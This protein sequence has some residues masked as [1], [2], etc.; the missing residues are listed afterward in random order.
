MGAIVI[1]V[2]ASMVVRYFRNIDTG[3]L[4]QKDAATTQVEERVSENSYTVTSGDTLWK[5]AEVRYQSGYNWVDIAQANDL[6]DPGQ[7][8]TGQV[9][10]LPNVEAKTVTTTQTPTSE[11][12]SITGATYSIQKG[13]SLWEIAVRA[14]G[15]GYRWTQIAQENQLTNPNLIHSGNQ[16]VLSR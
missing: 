6:A 8:E 7:I 12:D 16:L 10:Q 5:I 13:D 3:N 2:V 9:L 1:L 4:L 14:Y 11:K 15:D